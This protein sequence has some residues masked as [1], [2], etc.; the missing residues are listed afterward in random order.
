MT[1]LD[2]II[3]VEWISAKTACVASKN[4]LNARRMEVNFMA[5]LRNCPNCGAPYE[6]D[7]YRC[8]YCATLYYD[9]SAIDMDHKEPFYMKIR[10]NGATITQLVVPDDCEFEMNEDHVDITGCSGAVVGS[11]VTSRSLNTRI[12]F[13]AIKMPGKNCLMIMKNEK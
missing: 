5:K 11:Y 4:M 3:W 12:G 9:M 6:L 1:I 10:V 13:R 7:T 8:P 2:M